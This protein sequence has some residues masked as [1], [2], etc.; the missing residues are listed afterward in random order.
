LGAVVSG[1][2]RF[3]GGLELRLFGR[4]QEGAEPRG[5]FLLAAGQQLAVR[6]QV[7]RTS[8]WP[9]QVEI[10]SAVPCWSHRS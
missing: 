5:G 8:P 1:R 6:F 7:W 3:R 9:A 4:L 10:C 2:G